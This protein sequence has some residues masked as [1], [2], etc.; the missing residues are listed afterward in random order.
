[1]TENLETVAKFV[2]HPQI[3]GSIPAVFSCHNP[4]MSDGWSSLDAMELTFLPLFEGTRTEGERGMVAKIF[5][6]I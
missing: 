2:H 4:L 3:C 5:M 1:M 6:T